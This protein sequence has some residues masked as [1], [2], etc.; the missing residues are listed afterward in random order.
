MNIDTDFKMDDLVLVKYLKS[1]DSA[2]L[3][4]IQEVFNH[5]KDIL[6]TRIQ[7]VFPNYTLHNTGHSFRIMEYMSKL[8]GD[9][10]KLNELEITLLI[11]SALLHDIGMAVSEED[12]DL[13][14]TDSFPFCDVKFSAM[15]K[16]MEG[17]EEMALQE[18]IRRIHASLSGR[19]INTN[20]KDKLVIPKLI[21]LDFTKE[22]ALI[23]QSHTEDY[24]W[25]QTNLRTNEVRGD[26][27]FNSQFIAIILRLA[28]ILDIDGNRTP[29][30]LYKLISPKG[31]SDEEW[32][33]HFVISNNEKIIFNEK[34]Q[35]KKIVFHGKATNASIHR[36][37]LTYISWV[38]YELM[39]ASNLA[40]SMSSQYSLL[41]ETNPEVNIQTEGYSFSDYKMT[42]EFKAISSLLMGEKIYGSKSLGLRELIQNSIDSCRIRQETELLKYEFGEDSYLPKI[43]IILDKDKDQVIIKDNGIGMSMDIIKKHFLNIGVSYY[44]SQDF[45]LKDFEYKPIGNYGIGFLSC[46]MLSDD[47]KVL[48]RHYKLKTKYLIELEKENEWTSLTESEDVVFDGTE[49]ILKYNH[50]L[51]VFDNNPQTIKIFLKK[52]F[53]TDN[54]DFELIDKSLKEITKI[55]NQINFSFPLDKGQIKIDFQDYIKDIEGYALIK[56]R[57]EFIK[58]FDEINFIGDL[59]KY[60]HDRGVIEQVDLAT[61]NIDDYINGNEIKYFLIP[62]V[63]SHMEEDFFNGMKFTDD[64]L[65]EVIEKMDRDLT[66]ICV[67]FPKDQQDYLSDEK[68]KPN[69]YIFEKFRFEHLVE[70]GHSDS[71]VTKASV[72]TITLFEG[73]K[74]DLYL[75]FD[76]K[77]KDVYSFYLLNSQKRKELFMRSVLIKDFR[78]NIPVSASIFEIMSIVINIDSRKFIPEVSR[79]D[80]NKEAKDLINYIIGKAIHLGAINN[81]NLSFDEKATLQSFTNSFYERH[82]EFEK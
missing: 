36:K 15:K 50:F 12:I 10:S 54:I 16:I 38:K 58:N 78:F 80:I 39:N 13:I 56:P 25:I 77:D 60:D 30:N 72:E 47:V 1:I 20:L 44:N 28:D 34:T 6:N 55:D 31:V 41:Y 26:F 2:F 19:Y 66:W 7:H 40:N 59:Y 8:I 61:I 53:L 46:F 11:Y 9:I 52:Y 18:Y 49:V 75:P 33:Q 62:L 57:N 23:C 37:I 24:D 81:L 71:C 21:N 48:T 14:K 68:I 82:T 64:D 27:S 32:K 17:N 29:Y 42:L 22:L 74:N 65:D 70:I 63:E 73:R 45:L 79:N 67:I 76:T 35:Q 3:P 4:K 43:K 51:Q 5:V 69:D